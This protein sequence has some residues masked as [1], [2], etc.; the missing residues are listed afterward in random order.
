MGGGTRDGKG[1]GGHHDAIAPCVRSVC[2]EI[3]GVDAP[4]DAM[5]TLEGVERRGGTAAAFATYF[6]SLL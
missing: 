1:G 4:R 6:A 2:W 3:G 5:N